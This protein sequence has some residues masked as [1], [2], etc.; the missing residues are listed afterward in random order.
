MTITPTSLLNLPIITTGTESGVWG[1]DVNNGLTSYLDIAIAGTLNF[2]SGTCATLS[3]TSGTSSATNIGSTT[4]QYAALS[5]GPGLS[6]NFT[7]TAPASSK[8]Y[9]IVNLDSTYSAT[10]KAS[11]QT[12]YTVPKGQRAIVIFNGTDYVQADNYFN[13]VSITGGTITTA[14]LDNTPLGNTTPANASVINLTTSGT[15][16]FNGTGAVTLPVGTTAQEPGSPATGM[17]RFNTTLNQFEGYNGSIWGGIGGANAS[18]CIY[19]NNQTITSSY[20]F[21]SGT[22]GE[23]TGPITINSGVVITIPS[24]SRWVVL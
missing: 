7:L 20:T 14:T 2:N 8:I 11:G 9:Y 18:G 1:N 15:V 21:Q 24:G 22:S 4:A 19:V 12:G 17:I 6:G 23:S 16:T 5:F 10:I 13:N 3:N